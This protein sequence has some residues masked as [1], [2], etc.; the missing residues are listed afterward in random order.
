MGFIGSQEVFPDVK[1]RLNY[2]S[3]FKQ[4]FSPEVLWLP[5]NNFPNLI[6]SDNPLEVPLETLKLSFF[7]QQHQ[8]TIRYFKCVEVLHACLIWL[9]RVERL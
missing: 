3:I 1:V 8:K 2:F 5:T 4:A 7:F 9:R 6:N